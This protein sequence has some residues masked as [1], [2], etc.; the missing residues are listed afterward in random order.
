MPSLRRA[1]GPRS[2]AGRIDQRVDRDRRRMRQER[3]F[4]KAKISDEFRPTVI[5]ISDHLFRSDVC[6]RIEDAMRVREAEIGFQLFGTPQSRSE[7][8]ISRVGRPAPNAI[9]TSSSFSRDAGWDVGQLAKA[10]EQAPGTCEVGFLHTHSDDSGLSDSDIA[11]LVSCRELF[12]LARYVFVIAT[13]G[14]RGWEKPQ[15]AAWTARAELLLDT[16]PTGRVLVS[17]LRSSSAEQAER[18]TALGEKWEAPSGFV[19]ARRLQ[20]PS[21]GHRKI[22]PAGTE[23]RTWILTVRADIPTPICVLLSPSPAFH[24]LRARTMT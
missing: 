21:G 14:V 2:P 20:G 12:N 18:P 3:Q 7:L 13:P 11:H 10:R 1:A 6:R 17:G 5:T 19:E 4:E 8:H 23:R 9:R 24:P 15:L 22:A 16:F